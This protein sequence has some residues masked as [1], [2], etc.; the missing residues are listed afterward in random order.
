VLDRLPAQVRHLVF[1][2]APV[3]L[4]WAA[5]DVVPFVQGKNPLA[6]YLLGTLVAAALAYF[7]PATRQYGV[8]SRQA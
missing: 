4:G 3:L 1:L 5:S 7:T 8:G 6:A 2:V